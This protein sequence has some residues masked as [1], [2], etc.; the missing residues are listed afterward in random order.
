MQLSASEFPGRTACEG[1]Y[2]EF[3]G[4]SKDHER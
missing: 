2:K 1:K 3:E 4:I